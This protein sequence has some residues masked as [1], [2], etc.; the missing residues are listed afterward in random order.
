MDVKAAGVPEITGTFAFAGGAGAR[1]VNGAFAT[2][3][4]YNTLSHN[5]ETGNTSYVLSF[6]A[7]RSNAIYGK[8]QT[9]QVSA[10]GLIT[11]VKY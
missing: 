2:Q 10:L 5:S 9:V 8:S 4:S 11:Q 1:N 7:A 6:S 3:G